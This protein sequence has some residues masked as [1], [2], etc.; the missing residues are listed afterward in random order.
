MNLRHC[1]PQEAGDD[2]KRNR[3]TANKMVRETISGGEKDVHKRMWASVDQ[4][5]LM[6]VFGGDLLELVKLA[7]HKFEMICSEHH[8][9][10]FCLFL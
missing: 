7:S 4:M 10:L 2:T 8:I 5:C 9:C 3:E 6:G 1:G